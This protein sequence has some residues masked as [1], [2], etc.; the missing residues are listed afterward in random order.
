[1]SASLK[2]AGVVGAPIEKKVDQDKDQARGKTRFTL[3]FRAR[4]KLGG[5]G[6]GAPHGGVLGGGWEEKFGGWGGLCWWGGRLV[7]HPSPLILGKVHPS[8]TGGFS[9]QGDQGS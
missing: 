6:G 4:R 2:Q 3:K 9:H 1:V 5:G 8:V 7:I